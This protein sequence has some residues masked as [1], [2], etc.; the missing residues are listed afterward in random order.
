MNT[1]A[2]LATFALVVAASFGG[3]AA[4]GAAIGPVDV[5]D[6][7]RSSHNASSGDDADRP[8][9]LAVAEG[10]YRLSLES[11]T[12]GAGSPAQFSFRIVDDRGASVTEFQQLNDRPLHLIVLSRNLVDYLHLHPTIDATGRWTVDFPALEPGSYRVFADFEPNGAD[13]LTLGSDITVPGN[14]QAGEIPH[15]SA[16]STVGEYHVTLSGTPRVGDTELSFTVELN[17]N[18]VLP[19]PY[20]GAAGH[21]VAIRTGDLAYLHVHPH[22]G[23]TTSGVTFTGE[24]P[25]AGAYRL[26]FDFSHNGEVH[27]AAFTVVVP[28]AASTD[29][30]HDEGQ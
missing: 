30:S 21:L 23:D 10:G 4:V 7:D 18:A 24:F 16:A 11:D 1:G 25:T 26:F 14:L 15:P 22:Q 6:D 27:T 2:K 9:G 3:A 20:L 13:N 29:T 28:V 12:V 19:E 8:R 17:G 5:G